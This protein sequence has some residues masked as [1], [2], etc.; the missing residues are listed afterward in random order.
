MLCE[1]RWDWLAK[2][3]F[4][5]ASETRGRLTVVFLCLLRRFRSTIE[6]KK[7][8]VI[9]GALLLISGSAFAEDADVDDE[10]YEDV[11]RALL[12]VHKQIVGELG[13]LTYPLLVSIYLI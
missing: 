7:F 3:Q 8:L 2:T 10:S 4:W 9:L 6:M 1:D 13:D 11:D 12:L 5:L